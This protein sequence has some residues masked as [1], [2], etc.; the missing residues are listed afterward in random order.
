MVKKVDE[1]IAEMDG[2]SKALRTAKTVAE[3]DATL[4][5]WFTL[6]EAHAFVHVPGVGGKRMA[7]KRNHLREV[8]R[9]LELAGAKA[10]AGNPAL[11]GRI[12]E[13]KSERDMLIRSIRAEEDRII[14]V[15]S[16]GV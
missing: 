6:A 2:Y 11:G 16:E 4:N 3:Q 1:I 8:E 7:A 12:R 15:C 14:A 5:K 10:E 13:L 9:S